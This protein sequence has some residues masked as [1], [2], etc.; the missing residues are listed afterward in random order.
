MAGTRTCMRT[1]T[2]VHQQ[3]NGEDVAS[4]LMRA[5]VH[6]HTCPSADEWIEMW[7]AHSRARVH[8][9]VH[10]QMNGQRTCGKHTHACVHARAHT[11]VHQQM[12]G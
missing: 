7:Q 12:N 2:H 11:H 8:T 1:H 10:Q 9:H 3:M 6:T 4:T 5:Y